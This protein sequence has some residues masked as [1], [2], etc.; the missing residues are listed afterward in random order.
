MYYSLLVLCVQFLLPSL[1]L[2]LAH[3]RIYRKLAA[4]HFW[5]SARQPAPQEETEI[6]MN[7]QNSKKGNGRRKWRRRRGHKTTYL[8]VSVV[9]VFMCSWFPLNMLNV[10][11]DLGLYSKLFRFALSFPPNKID[12]QIDLK[13]F[14]EAINLNIIVQL[15]ISYPYDNYN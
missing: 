8:L 12:L 14:I 9:V 7:E 6:E 11:L 13:T 5:G 15:M 2:L 4:L 3:V 10:L 1:I